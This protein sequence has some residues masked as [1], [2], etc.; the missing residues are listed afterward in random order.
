VKLEK[1]NKETLAKV[2][3]NPSADVRV[4][5]STL[6]GFGVKV[7]PAGARIAVYQYRFKGKTRLL[8]IGRICDSLTLDQ[9]RRKA[10]EHS[11]E[12]FNGIDPQGE[13]EANRNAKTIGD[14]LD[15]YLQSA[16]FSDKAESTR[17]TDRGRIE[18][19][20]RPL[21]GNLIADSVTPDQIAKARNAIEAGKTAVV[22]KTAKLRGKAVVTGGAGAAR[23]SVIL[24][25][26]IYNWAI[27]E[28][29]LTENP[30]AKVEIEQDGKRV[31]IIDEAQYIALFN[32]LDTLEDQHQIARPAA[33]AIRL[34]AF[35]GARRGEIIGLRWRHID[36]AAGRIV[37]TKNEHKT[38]KKTQAPRII[39]LPSEAL[40]II[41][42]QAQREPDDLVFVPDRGEG[43]DLRRPWRVARAAA[44]L[45]ADFVLHGLRHS[46]GSHLAMTGENMAA[47][48][49]A[50]GHRQLATAQRYI[51]FAE[52]ARQALTTK[53]AAPISAA[54]AK[55]EKTAA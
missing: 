40:E 47:I 6:P 42:R 12:V 27:G 20:I 35:T 55:K 48:Q 5:D 10:K 38:G 22:A 37:I 31:A 2:A 18:R 26:A 14:L 32:A 28:K 53:A 9:A 33:D 54:F 23:K 46:V 44:G 11:A 51:H 13:K 45:P 1:L 25:R 4:W 15:S 41:D 3:I 39:G 17:D 24:L 19:H 36:R 52:S 34:I 8:T 49:T 7:T 16:A 50:L 21:L 29:F 43:I 30:A